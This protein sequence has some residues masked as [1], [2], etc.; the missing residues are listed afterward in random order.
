MKNS[1]APAH[2]IAAADQIRARCDDALNQIITGF[3]VH[4]DAHDG[5]QICAWADVCITGSLKY[6]HTDTAGL[7]AS[8]VARIATLQA[9]LTAAGGE[10][11]Q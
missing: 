10:A 6:S 7:L 8:A 4:A 5:E 11:P 1:H 9:E 2:V 3:Q